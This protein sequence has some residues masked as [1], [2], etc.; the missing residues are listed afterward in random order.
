MIGSTYICTIQA[1]I[2]FHTFFFRRPKV[3]SWNTMDIRGRGAGD[4]LYYRGGGESR[5]Q[6][7]PTKGLG[8]VYTHTGTALIVSWWSTHFAALSSTTSRPVNSVTTT[9]MQAAIW[10]EI[11]HLQAVNIHRVGSGLNFGLILWSYNR[12]SYSTCIHTRAES[13]KHHHCSDNLYQ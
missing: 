6:S 10:Q 4:L 2:C 1:F 11:L 5:V 3:R 13:W 12:F 8:Q 9:A 7:W